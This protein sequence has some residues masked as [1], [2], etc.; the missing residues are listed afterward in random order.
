MKSNKFLITLRTILST[1]LVVMIGCTGVVFAVLYIDTFKFDSK[2]AVTAISVGLISVLCVMTV[3]F[4]NNK[5]NFIYKLFFVIVS[6]L[7][8]TLI[9]LYFLKISGF[10]QKFDSVQKFRNYIQSFGGFAIII[11]ILIQFLQVVILPIP[12]FITVGAGVL[13]FGVFW[14]AIYSCIGIISGSLVAF[15]VGRNLGVKVA[16]WLIGESNLNKGLSLIKGKDKIALTFMF[17]FPFFPDDL[18]CFVAGIT[19]ISSKFFISMIF[20]TRIISVFASSYSVNNS[21]I[22]YNTWWGIIL[23][24][25]FFIITVLLSVLISKKGNKIENLFNKLKT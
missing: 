7:S 21:L 6:L 16:V 12:S 15:Y 11:F 22:P 4:Y 10:L 17:L 5:K 13:L 20:V 2:E 25:V 23:W 19:S 1:V 24:V 18:L 3:T 14:G 8:I 9:S